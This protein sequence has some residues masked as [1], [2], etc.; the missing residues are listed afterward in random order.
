MKKN[1]TRVSQFIFGSSLLISTILGLT[2]Y[3]STN[4]T[5]FNRYY[6]YIEYFLGNAEYTSREQGVFYFWTVYKVAEIG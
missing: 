2:F 3:D 5:D 6:R 1:R 4:G